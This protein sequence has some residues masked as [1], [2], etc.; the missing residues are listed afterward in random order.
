[1]GLCG[2]RDTRTRTH[3]RAEVHTHTSTVHNF[4]HI[5]NA[6]VPP[7]DRRGA[8]ANEEWTDNITE[9]MLGRE[10]QDGGKWPQAPTITAHHVWVERDVCNVS[11]ARRECS[12]SMKER[13]RTHSVASTTRRT[14]TTQPVFTSQS[15]TQYDSAP[16]ATRRT[17][18]SAAV[19]TM[20]PQD[21]TPTKT[22]SWNRYF[23]NAL[24]INSIKGDFFLG[25][26]L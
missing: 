17:P 9:N 3:D 6:H 12:V 25:C 20:A 16:M 19:P 15:H 23:L 4:S 8:T 10:S 22:L 26:V 7:F 18:R 13:G 2:Q 24:V 1:V 5:T 14:V 21:A 11:A